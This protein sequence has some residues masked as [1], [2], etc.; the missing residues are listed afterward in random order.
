M[1]RH[2]GPTGT[3]LGTELFDNRRLSLLMVAGRTIFCRMLLNASWQWRT[4]ARACIVSAFVLLLVGRSAQAL[5]VG[6]VTNSVPDATGNPNSFPGWIHGDPGWANVAAS[7]NYVYL[8][9][10][11]V[12]SARHVGY[13]GPITFQTPSG[14]AAF[15]RIPGSY[16]KDYG[17]PWVNNEHFYAVENP[18]SVQTESGQNLSL[19]QFSDLQIFRINGD[20]ELPALTIA[21]QP[22]SPGNFV[23]S[24]A[25]E[26]VMIG[27]STGRVSPQSQW[28][29]TQQSEKE[30][31]WSQQSGAGQYQGYLSDFVPQKRWG[32]NRVADPRPNGPGDISDPGAMDYT[33]L[34]RG[35]VSD[36]TSVLNLTFGDGVPRDMLVSMVVYDQPGQP[37]TPAYGVN[38]LE[39]QAVSNDS[40]SSVFVKRNGQWELAGIVNATFTYEDQP[41][42]S[43]MYGN[44]TAFTD[45]SRYNQDYFHSLKDIMESHADYSAMGDVNLD[46]IVS[47]NG[48]GPA[49]TDDVAAFVAGWNYNNGIG[50][51]TITSWKNGDLNRDGR[52]N[53]AD[54]LRLRGAL[55]GQIS[56]A[57]VASLF[58]VAGVPE[59]STAFLVVV[60][61]SYFAF[62]RRRRQIT[63]S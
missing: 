27:G 49:A 13:S 26:V 54:F 39:V 45:L 8:G 2:A 50:Q 16:Y 18:S 30:W 20:P 46:G 58:G 7:G 24:N 3:R 29:V 43:A 28:N 40:G 10:G 44:T 41:F 14:P 33:N 32:T 51:G 38:N 55:N 23:R 59:P 37:G 4:V 57:V 12:L 47:G 21:S 56:S 35:V 61:A 22:L 9:D 34:F 25:P 1:G 36:T 42:G 31:I 60:A 17:Y 15:E 63:T 5:I 52:T 19:S 11:W 6:N 53:V 62:S 48:T